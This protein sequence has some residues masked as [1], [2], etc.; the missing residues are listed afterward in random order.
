[1]PRKELN[2][3]TFYVSEAE[4]ADIQAAAAERKMSVSKYILSRIRGEKKE[5]VMVAKPDRSRK[6]RKTSKEFP[7]S[8]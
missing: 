5:K 7:W 4:K 8:K 3:I 1:M 6:K 2:P